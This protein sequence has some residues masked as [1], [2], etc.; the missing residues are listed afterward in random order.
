[1]IDRRVIFTDQH[2]VHYLFI[3]Q[4]IKKKTQRG[5][6]VVQVGMFCIW[7]SGEHLSRTLIYLRFVGNL[8]GK[9]RICN[10]EIN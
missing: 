8:K 7:F 9:A 4:L 5:N 1:M 10:F 6:K 2:S 3:S